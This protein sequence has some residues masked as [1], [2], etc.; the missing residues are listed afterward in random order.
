MRAR[1]GSGIFKK[2]PKWAM[3]AELAKTSRRYARTAARISP[4]WVEPLAR[5]S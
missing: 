1:P 4:N 3:A 5:T 2:K